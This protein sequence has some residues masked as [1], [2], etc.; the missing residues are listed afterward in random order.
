MEELK[1][2]IKISKR[3]LEIDKSK[4]TNERWSKGSEIYFEE[5]RKEIQEAQ[6]ENKENN[7]VKLE[8]ELGD[9][10]WDYINLLV[11]LEEEKK[12]MSDNVF[13]RATKKYEERITAIENN[14]LWNEIKKKQKE[15]IK[16]EIKDNI[17]KVNKREE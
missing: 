4:D 11:N 7:H 1:K 6:E 16:K 10:L 17:S 15:Q 3:K 13:Q 2:L 8:D 9:V 14:V 12:I 5:L